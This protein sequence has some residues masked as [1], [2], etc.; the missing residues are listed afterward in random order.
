MLEYI[1]SGFFHHLMSLHI[2]AVPGI[3]FFFFF[4]ALIKACDDTFVFDD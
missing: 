1:L 4:K 2:L 3:F